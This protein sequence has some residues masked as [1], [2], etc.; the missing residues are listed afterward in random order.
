[1]TLTKQ[2]QKYN[3][4]IVDDEYLARKLLAGYLEKIPAINLVA[5]CA[6]AFE[7]FTALKSYDIDIMMLDIHMPDLNGM[8]FAK[9]CAHVPA[10][11]FTTAYSEYAI[12]SY[13]INA[14]DYLLKPIG[15]PRFI[16]AIEKA[17]ERVKHMDSDS[18]ENTSANNNGSDLSL[19]ENEA[20]FNTQNDFIMV[21]ADYRYY[22]INID[23]LLYIEGQHEY[24]SFYTTSKRIT[25][26]Y[27]LK[28]L[29]ETLPADRFLR[30]HKS[31]IV[32]L[33]HIQ[34]VSPLHLSVAGN[35]IPIGASYKESLNT[36]LRIK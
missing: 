34:E 28:S 17:I 33:K 11:I 29:E 22:K 25:A 15:L 6:N 16:K 13:E 7:A 23:E 31:Y 4:I 36:K 35:K 26:L 12:D 24:V 8:E 19:A 3:A 27:S 20:D 1:M 10:I 21:K 18:A 30:V 32:S 5:T 9:T 2:T 14:V